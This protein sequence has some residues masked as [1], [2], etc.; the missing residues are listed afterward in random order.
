MRDGFVRVAVGTPEIHVADCE[1]NAN[2]VIALMEEAETKG[3]KLLNLP[4]LCLVGFTAQDLMLHDTLIQ[5]AAEALNAVCRA[6][7]GKQL[8]V[9]VGLP[10]AERGQL[11]NCAAVVQGG[12]V[13]GVVPKRYPGHAERRYFA[14]GMTGAHLLKICGMEAPFGTNILFECDEL[15]EFRFA[16]EIG[17]DMSAPDSPG[18]HHALAGATVIAVPA[19]SEEIVGRATFLRQLTSSYSARLACACLYANAGRGESTQDLVF[20]GHSLIAEKGELLAESK[21]YASGLT[22]SEID[23]GRIEA[24]RRRMGLFRS[25]EEYLSC[26]FHM[27]LVETEISR[28]VDPMPFVPS[29]AEARDLR[30][31]DILN[32]QAQGLM[33]RIRHTHC[34]TAVIGVSGGLDSTLALLVTE[35]AFR[36]LGLPASGILAVTMPCFGTTKRTRSNAE[37]LSECLG[38]SFREVNI[39]AVVTQHFADIGQDMEDHGVTF[40]NG[41]ARERTQVLMDI[42]NKCGGMVIGTGDLSELAL[43]WATYNGDHMSMYGVNGSVPKTLVR[44]LVHHVA[45]HA[46][47]EKLRSVLYDILDTPVSP[48]LLPPVDGDIAQKTED[49]VGP[50]ELHD[51]FLYHLMRRNSTPEKI[52]RIAKIAFAGR[53][54]EDTIVKWLKVFCRRFF[55]Q[56]F[57]RSCL[58]DGPKVGSVAVSPRGELCMPS[59]AVGALWQKL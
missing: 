39:A 13:L 59:D 33:Q 36:L 52:L 17:S 54:D 27:D 28:F 31:E 26:D 7:E 49:L 10:V 51:F 24:E 58:P 4:E 32:I 37:I 34:R 40:E 16:V 20:S 48:E 1:F 23:L 25:M 8:I 12:G 50:Y 46:E 18:T 55:N 47:D 6:S 2:S 22:V 30:C 41:Q 45:E 29:D 15:P 3:V 44:F 21:R 19:A 43:G 11:Y 9:V 14:P 38:M 5:G 56:Q 42:A 53:Y 57:K 35:R